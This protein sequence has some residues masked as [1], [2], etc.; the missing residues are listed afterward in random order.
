MEEDEPAVVPLHVLKVGDR[1][2]LPPNLAGVQALANSF[3]SWRLIFVNVIDAF[4][5][6]VNGVRYVITLNAIDSQDIGSN[7]KYVVCRLVILEKAWLLTSWGSKVRELQYTNCSSDSDD[8]QLHEYGGENYQLNPI[9]N[10]SIRGN[11]EITSDALHN[12][13]QQIVTTEETTANDNNTFSEE[14]ATTTDS[15]SLVLY[16]SNDE[17]KS[18]DAGFFADSRGADQFGDTIARDD[19]KQG[20]DSQAQVTNGIKQTSA[21]LFG[22]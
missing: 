5:E 8:D 22:L 21:L 14:S 7:P 17:Q 11:S 3:L 16:P 12:I 19:S 10:S 18:E 15:I 4:R 2:Y 20:D 6:V 9:F 1:E 13:E